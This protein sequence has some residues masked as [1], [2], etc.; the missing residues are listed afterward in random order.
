M[1]NFKQDTVF[2]CLV[3]K[4]AGGTDKPPKRLA[5]RKVRSFSLF[6]GQ[7]SMVEINAIKK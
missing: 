6:L 1:G 5:R 2:A 4:L 7:L 3:A